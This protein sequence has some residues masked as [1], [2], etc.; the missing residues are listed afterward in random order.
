VSDLSGVI[1]PVV[2]AVILSVTGSFVISRLSGPAQAA[3]IAALEGRLRVVQSDR[4]ESLARIAKL[5][6]RIALLEAQVETL[7]HEAI[8]KDREL[9]RLYR[10]LDADE[11]RILHDDKHVEAEP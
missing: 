7:Q 2:V 3:Y 11:R 1:V 5:E 4:D 8:A 6:A 9:A 10:R